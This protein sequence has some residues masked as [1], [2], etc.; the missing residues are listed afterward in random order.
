MCLF[1]IINIEE[2]FTCLNELNILLSAI[3]AWNGECAWDSLWS[4][5]WGWTCMLGVYI[6][7]YIYIWYMQRSWI[8]S[9]V[10]LLHYSLANLRVCYP[11]S[12]T[13]ITS[14]AKRIRIK[15][16]FFCNQSRFN[17]LVPCVSVQVKWRLA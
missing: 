8:L 7:I 17:L 1:I 13:Y 9:C 4:S 2:A 14:M 15:N 16:Y 11:N 3:V 5:F 6:Y 10:G 12:K